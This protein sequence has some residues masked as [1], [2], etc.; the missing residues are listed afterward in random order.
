[1][2]NKIFVPCNLSIA[3]AIFTGIQIFNVPYSYFLNATS[4]IKLLV[5]STGFSLLLYFSFV[6][7]GKN[8]FSNS[9]GIVFASIM[10]AFSAVFM[11][12]QTYKI[13]NKTAKGIWNE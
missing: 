2:G 9:T 6:L 13:L 3:L 1:M 10:T 12:F 5:Y 11:P 4:K 8:L 7:I